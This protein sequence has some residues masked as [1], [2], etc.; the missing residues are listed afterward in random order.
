M[1]SPQQTFQRGM[2]DAKTAGE[3]RD[4]ETALTRYAQ[5]ALVGDVG[6]GMGWEG[7]CCC[8]CRCSGGSSGGTKGVVGPRDEDCGQ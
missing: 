7:Y 5:C 6:W 3:A 8:N 1:L 2:L 4:F